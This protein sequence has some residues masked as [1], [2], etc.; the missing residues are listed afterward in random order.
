MS[1]SQKRQLIV[2]CISIPDVK[3][4]FLRYSLSPIGFSS[5]LLSLSFTVHADVNIS[6]CPELFATYFAD[7]FSKQT[8]IFRRDWAER[9]H[10]FWEAYC[11][12]MT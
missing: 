10:S 6:V 8:L 4:I 1:F 9:G 3:P 7:G 5:P 11:S 12:F 2:F